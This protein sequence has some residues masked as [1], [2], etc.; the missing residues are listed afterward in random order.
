MVITPL[1]NT[2]P[3]STS[4]TINQAPVTFAGTSAIAPTHSEEATISH[5]MNLTLACPHDIVA[6][7]LLVRFPIAVAA[8]M[9]PIARAMFFSV[10]PG[11]PVKVLARTMPIVPDCRPVS[12]TGMNDHAINSR[13]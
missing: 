12:I 3:I 7:K 9:V 5:T 11:V 6:Q 13:A 10:V 1:Q 8:P 4:P 2:Q